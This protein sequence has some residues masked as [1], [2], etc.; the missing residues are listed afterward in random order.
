MP[1]SSK[2]EKS[3]NFRVTPMILN[4]SLHR[5][6]YSRAAMRSMLKPK[7]QKN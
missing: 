6:K 2:V 4:R 7:L 3:A 1:T 5:V